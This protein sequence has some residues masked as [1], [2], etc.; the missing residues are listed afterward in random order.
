M[1]ANLGHAP[2][3]H[4]P[5]QA[6]VECGRPVRLVVSGRRDDRTERFDE[7]GRTLVRERRYGSFRRQF[8]LPEHVSADDVTASYE[9][10]LLR[11][12]VRGVTKELPEARKIAIEQPGSQHSEKTEQNTSEAAAA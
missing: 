7:L 2:R 6:A 12:L 3:F 1:P 11:V 5:G 8:S 10:G 9:R 4:H